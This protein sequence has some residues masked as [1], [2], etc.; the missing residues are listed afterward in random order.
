MSFWTLAATMHGKGSSGQT[1]VDV[2]LLPQVERDR[3]AGVEGILAPSKASTAST[4]NR[5]L[6]RWPEAF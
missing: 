5:A 2:G 3:R 4:A 6:G 1:V